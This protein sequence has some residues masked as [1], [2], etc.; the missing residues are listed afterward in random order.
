[1]SKR[2]EA[3]EAMFN[4]ISRLEER[5]GWLW[6]IVPLPPGKMESKRLA[7]VRIKP[8]VC[9]IQGNI[10]G[11]TY[12]LPLNCLEYTLILNSDWPDKVVNNVSKVL[13]RN[14]DEVPNTRDT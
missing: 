4:Q 3:Q 8:E 1:M 5:A 14:R 9:D 13:R 2:I 7:Q 6:E 10:W 12:N 11:I